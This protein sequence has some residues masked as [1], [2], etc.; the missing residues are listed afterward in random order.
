MKSAD[1]KRLGLIF[2]IQAEVE[3]MKTANFERQQNDEA[4]AYNDEDFQ[5]KASELRNVSYCLDDQL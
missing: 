4:M 3:G 2:S 5:S 1:V